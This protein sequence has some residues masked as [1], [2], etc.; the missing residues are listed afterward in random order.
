MTSA[1]TISS[2]T[3]CFYAFAHGSL[4]IATE[5]LLPFMFGVGLSSV[6][7]AAN[8]VFEL[9]RESRIWAAG[10]DR[11]EYFVEAARSHCLGFPMSTLLAALM[12]YSR[13]SSDSELIALRS[14]G[15]SIPAGDACRHPEL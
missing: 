1:A 8:T 11:S 6:V 10:S 3:C 2:Q 4:H 5:L 12:T 15:M 9:V 7:V 14:C 13:L